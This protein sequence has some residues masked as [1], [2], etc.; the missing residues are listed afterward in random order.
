[1]SVI[2]STAKFV[3]TRFQIYTFFYFEH[4]I[5]RRIQTNHCDAPTT[6]TDL[7]S[8]TDR[9]ITAACIR[10]TDQFAPEK[11]TCICAMDQFAPENLQTLNQ[12]GLEA[13]PEPSDH[14]QQP[15]QPSPPKQTCT[16]ACT[17]TG[18]I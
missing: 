16:H 18:L 2:A 4:G 1:M 8:L 17:L 7:S 13:E 11:A 3:S 10:A 15:A 5:A 9:N 12:A 14:G 6:S